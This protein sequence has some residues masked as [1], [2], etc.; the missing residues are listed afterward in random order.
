MKAQPQKCICPNFF[1]SHILFRLCRLNMRMMMRRMLFFFWRGKDKESTALGG[2]GGGVAR[3]RAEEYIA[4]QQSMWVMMIIV[5]SVT[6]ANACFGRDGGVG[7]CSVDPG[8]L[9]V[10]P[11]GIALSLMMSTNN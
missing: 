6:M 9:T 5:V 11:G 4:F 1:K 3:L 8:R 10:M 2:G 7:Y